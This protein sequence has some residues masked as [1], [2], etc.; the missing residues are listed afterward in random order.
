MHIH[1]RKARRLAFISNWVALL[2][3]LPANAA[4]ESPVLSASSTATAAAAVVKSSVPGLTLDVAGID[5]ERILKAASAALGTE[6]ITIANFRAELSEGGANDF[7]SNGDYWWPDPTKTNG[8]PYVQRDGESNPNNFNQHRRCIA[9]L[10]EAVAAL[11]AAYKITG[12]D[13]YA[14]K[15]V[16][17][18]R[19]FFFD[20]KTRMNPHLK[21]AQAIPGRTPGRGTGIIDTLHLIEVPVAI[22]ALQKS[23]A[24]PP[25]VLTGLKEWFRQY[26]EWMATSK[27][28]QDEAA[29]TNNHSVAFYLQLAA[30]AEFAGDD[31]RVAECRRRFKEVFVP[32]QMA[33]DGSFPA[34][35]KR[36]KPYGYSIF[37][38]DN[39][40]ALC[41]LLSTETDSLWSF[42][43]PDGRGIRKAVEFLYPYLADKSTW[44]RQPDIQA[45]NG[46]P[47]RQPALLFAGLAFGEQKYLDLWQKLPADPVDPEVRRNIAITQPLLWLKPVPQ[48]KAVA[49]GTSASAAEWPP[50]RGELRTPSAPPTP[51]IN[52]PS[53]YGVRP[54]SPFL[55][56]IPASGERPMEF[57]VEGLPA[58]L[59][60]AADTGEISGVLKEPGRHLVTLRARNAKG[61]AGKKFRI[62]A[63]ETIALTPPMGWNSWNCWGSKVD[64]EKVLK[65]ARGLVASGL[66]NHGWTYMNIDDAWQG[67]RGGPFH[68]IQGNEKFPD[69]KDLCD[70]VHQ[71]GLKIGI[72]STPWVTSYAT[73]IG[74]SAENPEG[75]WSSPTIPKRGNVNKKILPWAI[76]K[77]HFATN[78]ASQWA[79]WGIDYLKYDWN[80]NELP[81]TQ[82]MYDALR[83]SGR[84]VILSLSNN[85]PFT[86]APALSKIANCWRTTGDIRD[87][88]DSMSK[89]GFGEDKWERFAAP[90][91]WND[92]DMLVVGRVG[93]GSPHPTKLTPDEQY[94]HISL[95]CLLS[96]PLLL[97]CDLDQLDDFTLNLLTNDEVLA[98]NQDALGKQALCVARDGD[99]R[100][101]A[102]DLE[103][104]SKAVGLFNLG[105]DTASV[106]VKWSDLR[107][108][109]GQ[110]VRDLW[111][112]KDVGAFGA[113]FQLPV[114]GHGA[115]LVKLTPA[116]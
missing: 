46:W 78:D 11:G 77:Y 54:G 113:Q 50:K 89:K 57:S 33:A 17:L 1:S 81:E 25:E 96:A 49:S 13:R 27:N 102:K 111:R 41:Q 115:E 34:E 84:D 83:K 12:D 98:V 87:N 104:G 61:T 93:W 63:G 73:Y 106:T 66:I 64:A 70:T 80:P 100:V 65:S 52:G 36:T 53:I 10:H 116:Q 94:T 108:S 31:A 8:L 15:A 43:L 18:L 95:W 30:F 19:V 86:N 75:T 24:F 5:R 109:G 48:A 55:Y 28:G 38:L 51:R 9:Q 76:G 110:S 42:A 45:W 105:A 14:S 69:M 23:P 97:G 44:P 20:P 6:L 103:D 26:A 71:M 32:K 39:M 3:A 112:Q 107:L 47:A 90:G 92:P 37:Q 56:H 29:A 16:E 72:Y 68:A 67:K 99:L 2:V 60:V 4:S 114:A 22:A 40:A 21:Y 58:G 35:L 79:A 7:Y 62:V 88:W 101:Y 85:S 59:Q 74:G 82:E 91:H